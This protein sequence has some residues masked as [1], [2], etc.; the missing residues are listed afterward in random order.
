MD[1]SKKKMRPL[2]TLG[3]R[4]EDLQ[5]VLRCLDPKPLYKPLNKPLNAKP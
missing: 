2:L 1:P 5:E 4:P 3:P